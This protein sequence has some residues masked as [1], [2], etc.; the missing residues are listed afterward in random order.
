MTSTSGGHTGVWGPPSNSRGSRGGTSPTYSTITVINTSER[1][2]KN[3]L[4]VRLEKQQGA[5]F[6]LSMEDIENLL[7]RLH[8][9]GSHLEGVSACPEGKPVVF[10]TLHPSVDITRFL[11]KNECYIVKEGVRTTTIRQEGKKDK[12]IRI[13]GL[14]PN[15]KDQAVV[16]Y[17]GAH[18][19]VSTTEKVIHHVFPGDPGSSLLAGKLN[20]NRSY[21]VELDKPMGSYHIIDG[22][23]VSIRYSGQ[24]WTCA[25]C[26]QLK[27]LCPG[28]AV[29]R[30]CTAERILLSDH[31]KIHWDKIGYKP[32]NEVMNEVDQVELEVQVGGKTK[33]PFIIPESSFTNRYNGVVIKGF[34]VDTPLQNISQ[35]L[36]EEGSL[37]E[38]REEDILRNEKTGNLTLQNLKS[39]E[40]L[41]VME[42][43]H[44]KRFLGRQV[45]ISSVVDQSPVKP[46]SGTTPCTSLTTTPDI[47]SGPA[48]LP[49]SS[50]P[51]ITAS[52]TPS[53]TASDIPQG[54]T[55]TSPTKP[56]LEQGSRPVPEP[57]PAPVQIEQPGPAPQQVDSDLYA[58]Q[59]SST[60]AANIGPQYPSPPSRSDPPPVSPSVQQKIDILEQQSSDSKFLGMTLLENKRKSEGSPE[61]DL[62]RN[63]KKIQ[64]SEGKKNKKNEGK[65]SRTLNL[66]KT[67]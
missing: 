58:G 35:L 34:K 40:C 45:F 10:I 41:L 20:G 54:T 28:A 47:A 12:I 31:M 30:N 27:S 4:E 39:E 43:M 55:S 50:T 57:E 67:F 21:V 37:K 22:E 19:K 38:L 7:K 17:L 15:T 18:G 48:P 1:E 62:T 26:H 6:N 53:G 42:N 14:H 56:A 65:A 60:A 16:K 3:I 2:K 61:A 32:D 64:K 49:A 63:E 13:T 33:E 46:A 29:A 59:N 51:S 52:G 36:K 44:G 8:I 23:K 24:E 5:S 9:D 25:R 11:N 66:P